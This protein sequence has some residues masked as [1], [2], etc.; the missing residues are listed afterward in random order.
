[1]SCLV[2]IALL[3]LGTVQPA[4]EPAP[5]STI[6]AAV[7]LSDIARVRLPAVDVEAA[8]ARDSDRP[9]RSRPHRVAVPVPVE[10][11]LTNAGTWERLADGA[12]LWRLRISSPGATFL[13]VKFAEFD[14]PLGGRLFAYTGHCRTGDLDCS[15][16]RVAG[17]FTT[18]RGG[19]DQRLGLPMIPGDEI[20]V[21]LWLP[22]GS[23]AASLRIESVSH[24]FRDPLGFAVT[25]P[26][27]GGSF[28]CQRDI[29]CPEGAPYQNEKRAVAEGY[30]GAF[31]CTGTMLNN[32]RADNRLLYLTAEHCEFW[33]D[34]QTM[35]YYWN[36]ENSGCGTHDAPYTYST[37]S[38][39][40]FHN[41][42]AD[43]QLLE[44]TGTEVDD[45]YDLWFAGWSR[46]VTPPLRG[47][48][49]SFPDDKPKRITIENDPIVD[50]APS[51]CP[52]GW[53][54]NFWRVADYD[55]GVTEGGSSGAAL[56]DENHRVVG[57]LTG[58][59][60]TDCNDFEWD[61]YAKLGPSWS[62]LAPFL[63]PTNTGAVA[64]DGRDHADFPAAPP[65]ADGA[66]GAPL[67]LGK[68]PG[69]TITMT[70]DNVTCSGDHAVLLWGSLGNFG[71]YQGDVG[72]ACDVGHDGSASV[73]FP[74]TNVWFNL[75]WVNAGSEAGHP[76]FATQ[77]PRTWSAV[78][79][80]G[81]T[82]DD[83]ADAGCD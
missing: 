53:G 5:Q 79:L 25:P 31:I 49:I 59:V 42:A 15:Q 22:P 46:S 44:L 74:G 55:V 56:L 24:G 70:Y 7:P 73:S 58:G 41:A 30:D 23:A 57:V 65:A 54:P 71:A 8:L 82:D 2:S 77:G 18:R 20:V 11:G 81:V 48:S 47:A 17:P 68:G 13:S 9:G 12:S 27:P 67:R 80:C 28:G 6:Q 69:S 35:T 76:G 43:I 61:E 34:P 72:A 26:P 38:T 21:E 40:L 39:N 60:G 32:T 4:A 63:D 10:F 62:A 50:C 3:S 36:Y 29:N 33:T 78:G 19:A 45:T 37:G 51:G 1:M 16:N 52:D 75:V 64:L 83:I 66:T 14:L